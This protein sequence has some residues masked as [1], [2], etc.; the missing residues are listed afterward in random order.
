MEYCLEQYLLNAE[1]YYSLQAEIPEWG[2]FKAHLEYVGQPT[3]VDTPLALHL[4]RTACYLKWKDKYYTPTE[5][6]EY[7]Q[8]ALMY[9]ESLN[10]LIRYV[11]SRKS[12][13]FFSS[14][15]DLFPGWSDMMKVYRVAI[16]EL[17]KRGN[18]SLALAWMSGC[19]T[20]EQLETAVN[21][22]GDNI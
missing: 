22:A 5:P 6:V 10:N 12:F 3:S 4:E 16:L 9:I 8:V 17:F 20:V 7:I 21:A 11:E 14:M 19:E 2:V 1:L 15:D 13:Q 18:D